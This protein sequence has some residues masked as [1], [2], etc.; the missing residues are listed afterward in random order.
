MKKTIFYF[1][2]LFVFLVLGIYVCLNFEFK[3][4]IWWFIPFFW[5]FLIKD[6][7]TGKKWFEKKQKKDNTLKE[8]KPFM[9]QYIEEELDVSKNEKEGL[10]DIVK[11]CS[12]LKTQNKL[13]S[14]IDTNKFIEL[15]WYELNEYAM[16]KLC[17]HFYLSMV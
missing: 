9:P 5:W 15:P 8:L 1:I 6:V 3:V 12:P 17:Y 4:Y 10:K 11:L 16:E 2:T 7:V 13:L 14:F